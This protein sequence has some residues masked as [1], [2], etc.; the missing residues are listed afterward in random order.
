MSIVFAA[1][2]PHTPLL[3]PSIGKDNL[4]K[5]KN[6]QSSLEVLEKEIYASVPDSIIIMSP[7]G[8]ILKDSFAVHLDDTYKAIF[9]EFGDFSTSLEFKS[10]YETIQK[11]RAGD[12]GGPF[13]LSS[14]QN[15]DYGISVPLYYLMKHISNTSIIPIYYSQQDIKSFFEAGKRLRRILNRSEKRFAIIA[16][17]DLSH[18]L[19]KDAPA[20]YGK[21]ALL[22]EKDLVKYIKENNVK[23]ILSLKNAKV[24]KVSECGLKSIAFLLGV[25]DGTS[26]DVDILSHEYPFGVGYVVAQMKLH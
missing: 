19:T 25:L 11:I 4:K 18:K 10:D 20:G 13:V 9:K 17:A 26:Y 2:T 14:Y 22:F 7:H 24:E 3:I 16:S 8:P 6:T 1:I 12:E 15:I 5:L 23:K 21:G